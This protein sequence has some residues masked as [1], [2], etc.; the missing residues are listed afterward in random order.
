M[1][2]HPVMHILTKQLHALAELGEQW[3]RILLYESFQFWQISI[4]PDF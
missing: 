1:P 3:K 2:K 4:F